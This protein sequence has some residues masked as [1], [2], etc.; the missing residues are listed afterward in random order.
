MAEGKLADLVLAQETFRLMAA[1]QDARPIGGI[2]ALG[3]QPAP[4]TIFTFEDRA[5]DGPVTP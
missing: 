2:T 3:G 1:L 4:V 5:H